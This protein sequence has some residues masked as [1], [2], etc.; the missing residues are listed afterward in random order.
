MGMASVSGL[1]V[2]L[3][4]SVPFIGGSCL[5]SELNLSNGAT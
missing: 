4:G 3:A 2:V 1:E 5:I